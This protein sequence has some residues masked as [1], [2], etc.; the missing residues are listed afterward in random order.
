[1]TDVRA[2]KKIQCPSYQENTNVTMGEEFFKNLVNILFIYSQI[3]I[4]KR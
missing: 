3:K 4:F 1:M 2:I